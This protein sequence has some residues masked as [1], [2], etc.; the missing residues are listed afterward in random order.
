MSTPRT[1][2]F[3]LATGLLLA[4]HAHAQAPVAENGP[5]EIAQL[6]ELK[7]DAARGKVVFA[8]CADC[9]R[10]DASGRANGVFPRLAGQYASVL[11]KQLSDIRAG[12][13]NNASM[14]GLASSL[15]LADI[16]DVAA[17]LQSLPVSE[18]TGKGPGA[19]VTRGRQLYERD[20]AM[21][22]GGKG[23]GDAAKFY[24]M[25]AAQ[26]YRY[27]LREVTSIRDGDRGNSDPAMVRMVKNYDAV[28]IEAVADF[29][30]QL[31]PPKP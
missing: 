3:L 13:R 9:H 26:H 22:H 10:K 15:S 27:L 30:S 17:Y 7:G 14:L 12:R 2:L 19:A 23:E 25:I 28:D 31:P 1:A 8:S 16:A 5:S 20:C 29:M 11:M 24:P 21:C 4:A 18:R 6:L